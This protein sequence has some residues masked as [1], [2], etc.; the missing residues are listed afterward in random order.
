MKVATLNYTGTV[1]K[2]T[3]SSHL[4]SP[5]MGNAQEFAVESINETAAGLGMDTEKLNGNK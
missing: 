4:L 5:R 1:G 2:T 3:I